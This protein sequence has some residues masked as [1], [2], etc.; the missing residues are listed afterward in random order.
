MTDRTCQ[1][2]MACMIATSI[3]SF[4]IAAYKAGL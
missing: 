2:V 4:L 1:I 3:A